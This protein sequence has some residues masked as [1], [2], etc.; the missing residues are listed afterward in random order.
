LLA[1]QGKNR[2]VPYYADKDLPSFPR[3]AMHPWQHGNKPYLNNPVSIRRVAAEVSG[4]D[5]GVGDILNVLERNDLLRDT[6]IVY[7]SDQGW[8][9]GQNGMWGMGDHMRPV[10]A[11]ELMMKIPFIF[12]HPGRISAGATNELLVSN[13][14]FLPTVLGHLGLAAKMPAQPKSPGRDFSAAL[15][16]ETIPWENVVFYEFETCRAVRTDRWKLVLRHPS[17]P[18][19]FYDMQADPGERFNQYGQ[20]G[21]EGPRAELEAKLAKFFREYSD[22]QYDIWNGGRSKARRVTV[23]SK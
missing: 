14:D 23:S 22:P 20:P 5:D 10:G 3:D 12:H 7:A 4:V 13:Y 1:N 11:H 17:G 15:R 8:M 16:G 18:H 19:E 6:L 9:G 21:L 2:H